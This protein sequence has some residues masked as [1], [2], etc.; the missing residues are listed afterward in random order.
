MTELHILRLDNVGLVLKELS[1][2][3]MLI[4][5]TVELPLLP[6]LNGARVA[7]SFTFGVVVPMTP[8]I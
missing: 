6:K 3:K 7:C 8:D 4:G 1:R 5:I 2:A